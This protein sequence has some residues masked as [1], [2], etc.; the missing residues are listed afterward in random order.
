MVIFKFTDFYI[1]NT[2][3]Y[4]EVLDNFHY[5]PGNHAALNT[6]LDK[7]TFVFYTFLRENTFLRKFY[8]NV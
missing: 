8:R 6:I 4:M 5:V 3:N 1:C 2:G 7:N